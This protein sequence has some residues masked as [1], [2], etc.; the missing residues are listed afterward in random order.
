MEQVKDTVGIDAHRT[1]FGR[2]VCL[3]TDRINQA[4]LGWS[5]HLH[6]AGLA[7]DTE[8][9]LLVLVVVVLVVVG[10]ARSFRGRVLV[11]LLGGL[12][13]LLNGRRRLRDVVSG[14]VCDGRLGKLVC[15]FGRGIGAHGASPLAFGSHVA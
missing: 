9:L 4:G 3:V 8:V 5:L 11:M 6:C 14:R 1:A 15:S 13:G 7:I 12:S 10:R 2:R